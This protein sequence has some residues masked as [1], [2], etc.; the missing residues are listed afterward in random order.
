MGHPYLDVR[1]YLSG[2]R[3]VGLSQVAAALSGK[4]RE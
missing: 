4:I 1:K 2:N 3:G